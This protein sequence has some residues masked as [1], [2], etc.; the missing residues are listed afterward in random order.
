MSKAKPPVKPILH[1]LADVESALNRGDVWSDEVRE[2]MAYFG[3]NDLWPWFYSISETTGMEASMLID[4]TGLCYVD[5]G[6]VSRV[7]LNPPEGATIPFQ[8][9][10]HTHPKGFAYWSV[11]DKSTL[12]ITSVAKI[13]NK[14]I[15][16][17]KGEMKTTEWFE[18]GA[19]SPLA[20]DGPLSYWSDE[21][22]VFTE[23]GPSPWIEEVDA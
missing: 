3:V 17:G 6:T 20:F 15:V 1:P 22:V 12:A 8:V 23:C 21:S 9:W 18:S 16:L 19:E 10:T 5:W 2:T 14:A 11:T 13:L 7:G 4:A